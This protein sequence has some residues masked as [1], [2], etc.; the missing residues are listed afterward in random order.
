MKKRDLDF[1]N[2]CW[3]P[4][5]LS[6]IDGDG[7]LNFADKCPIELESLN[8]ILDTDGCPVPEIAEGDFRKLVELKNGRSSTRAK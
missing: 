2:I 5:I 4:I 8:G 3:N 1:K 7:I 6:D